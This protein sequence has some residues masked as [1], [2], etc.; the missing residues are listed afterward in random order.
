MD[1]QTLSIILLERLGNNTKLCTA[2]PGFLAV[3]IGQLCEGGISIKVP[4][5]V[6]IA[7]FLKMFQAVGKRPAPCC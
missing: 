3:E 1:T 5:V 2:V 6:A 7:F 4:L